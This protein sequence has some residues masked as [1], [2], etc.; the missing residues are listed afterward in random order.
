M[1]M[2]LRRPLGDEFLH[3]LSFLDERREAAGGDYVESDAQRFDVGG[4][5]PP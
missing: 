2:F 4:K 1:T 3:Q 5:G